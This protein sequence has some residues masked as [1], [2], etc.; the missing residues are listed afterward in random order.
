MGKAYAKAG[1]NI[2]E[3]D[4]LVSLIAPAARRTHNAMVHRGS[5]GGYA[6]V[7]KLLPDRWIAST[8][9]GVGTKVKLAAD[10]D[11]PDGIGQDLVAMS[12]N[13]LVCVGATPR[14]FLDYFA[15]GLLKPELA[16]RIINGVAEA[17][18]SIRL[19]LVGGETAEMP[20]VY[21]PGDYDLAGFA[22]GDLKP[23]E[24]LPKRLP[25]GRSQLA[26]WVLVGFSSTGFHSNGYSLVRKLV[27]GTRESKR[28]S[29]REDVLRPTALYVKLA[30]K[31][32]QNLETLHGLAHITGSG[33]LNLPRLSDS[34]DYYI[35]W[36]SEVPAILDWAC[37]R[38]GIS[39]RDAFETWNMGIGF[40]ALLHRDELSRAL[41]IGA[42]CG[43]QA[44]SIG[45]LSPKARPQQSSS[46]FLEFRGE[47]ISWT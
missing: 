12:V 16:A 2:E 30:L 13:D 25:K 23:G 35:N 21:A 10:W 3:G 7:M 17:C 24:F 43:F 14:A 45:F 41:R 15:T 1:V 44:E 46:I 32:R 47:K 4:R 6:A 8:T 36:P 40:V 29:F 26:S 33:I 5:L 11:M 22:W 20:G 18:F 39:V 34:C 42:R 27:K 38:G 31:L 9:D 37:Q 28:A 19:P